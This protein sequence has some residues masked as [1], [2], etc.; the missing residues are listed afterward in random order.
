MD[1]IDFTTAVKE[2]VK[3]QVTEKT[4]PGIK[5]KKTTPVSMPSGRVL[6]PLKK[7]ESSASWKLRPWCC[8]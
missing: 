4:S 6:R 8:A 7:S 2:R 1:G 3:V 5:R